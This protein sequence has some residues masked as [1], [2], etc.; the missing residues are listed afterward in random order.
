MRRCL[1]VVAVWLALLAGYF[2]FFYRAG[3]PVEGALLGGV[4]MAFL[5]GL[6]LA[7]MSSARFALRDSAVLEQFQRGARPADGEPA[8]V[9]GEIR[10]MFEPLRA[11]LSGRECVVYHYDVGPEGGGNEDGPRDYVGFA[12]ARCAIHSPSGTYA[13]GSFPVL[14]GFPKERGASAQAYIEATEFEDVSKALTLA[15]YTL[16]LHQQQPPL[17]IDWRLGE[18][19]K[20]P[21]EAREA[22]VESGARVTAYGRYSSA[23]NALVSG[24]QE[25]LRL[26]AGA[27]STLSTPALAQ[28]ITGMVLILVANV[29]MLVVLGNLA[30]L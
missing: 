11:P 12:F 17:R 29:G 10:P 24:E 4:M 20:G 26:Y 8:A 16:E 13:L 6:G 18:P 7:M 22:V 15:K 19:S 9:S 21:Q 14:N 2:F 1:V 25:Y 23:S 30:T 28:L 5:V 3:L 27:G